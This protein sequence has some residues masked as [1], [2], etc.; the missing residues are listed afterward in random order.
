MPARMDDSRQNRVARQRNAPYQTSLARTP[1]IRPP[2]A[3]P[4]AHGPSTIGRDPAV[5]VPLASARCRG[6]TP[7]ST[8]P[9]P[10][11]ASRISDRRTALSSTARGSRRPPRSVTRR[12]RHRRDEARVPDGYSDDRDEDQPRRRERGLTGA[13]SLWRRPTRVGHHRDGERVVRVH[14]FHDQH[15]PAVWPHVVVVAAARYRLDRQCEQPSG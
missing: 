9:A 8:C 6:T 5:T 2:T 14:R 13:R 3:Q 12:D 11:E 10:V 15:V 1:G 4:L 7:G